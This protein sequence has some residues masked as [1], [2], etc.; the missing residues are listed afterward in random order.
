ME[1]KNRRKVRLG[2]RLK[3]IKKDGEVLTY[4]RRV[5]K[6]FLTLCRGCPTGER[7]ELRVTYYPKITNE[8]EYET[9]EE[10]L[11]ALQCFTSAK[12][13]DFVEEYWEKDLKTK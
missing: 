1:R 13:L 8:G 3:V 7:Y 2:L 4:R 11:Y 10:M 12:E 6:S 5:L 9:K